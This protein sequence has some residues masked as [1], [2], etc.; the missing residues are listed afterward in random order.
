MEW[1]QPARWPDSSS[2]VTRTTSAFRI[3]LKNS[4]FHVVY[5]GG[6]TASPSAESRST[7]SSVNF[8]TD[9]I[10]P[11]KGSKNITITHSYIRAGDDN[12]A[13]KGGGPGE[14][15]NMTVSH[16]HFYWGHNAVHRV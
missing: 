14:L 2:T 3:A 5:N 12:V 10:S 6:E 4:L 11:G 8:N 1:R 13:I 7:R 16:S 15:T 9:G